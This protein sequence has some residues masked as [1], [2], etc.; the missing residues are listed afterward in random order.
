[1]KCDVAIKIDFV[2][3]DIEQLKPSYTAGEC[4]LVQPFWR[5]FFFSADAEHI[6]TCA[7]AVAHLSTYA[8]EM[9][10]YVVSHTG[11]PKNV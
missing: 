3:E 9:Y 7:L 11:S 5:L 1:M 6:H 4:K 8:T 10:R 2:G